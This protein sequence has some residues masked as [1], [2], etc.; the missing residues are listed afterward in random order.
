MII[1]SGKGIPSLAGIAQSGQTKPAS[2]STAKT[3]ARR[4]FDQI[5]LTAKDGD[6]AFLIEMKS[7]LSQE[8]RTATTT[9]TLNVLH[10][11]VQSGQYQADPA[12]I[13]RKILL[14]G[15]E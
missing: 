10:Q 7:R 15:E 8:V 5:T 12:A 13:G 14:L 9:G 4:K 3:N 1:F 6:S 2:G 11:Q